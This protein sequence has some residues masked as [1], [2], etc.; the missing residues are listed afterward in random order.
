VFAV[1]KATAAKYHLTTLS[2]L[3]PWLPSS[4]RRPGRVPTYSYC[5]LGL[6]KV[7]G[8]HFKSFVSTDEAGPS[9]SPTSKTESRRGRVLL[10]RRAIEE[11]GFVD[12]TDNK[13]LQ[14]ADHLVP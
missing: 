4:S 3:A 9:R 14:P 12:L 5:L 6:Q 2:S 1:T 10:E 11:N 8:I 7:Y 13:H